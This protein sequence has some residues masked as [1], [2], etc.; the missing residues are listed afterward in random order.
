MGPGRPFIVQYADFLVGAVRPDFGDS[1]ALNQP[2][3]KLLL[4]RLPATVQLALDGLIISFAF[5]IPLGILS[6]V[7][8]DSIFDKIGKT[9]AVFGLAAPRFWVAIMLIILFGRPIW[10]AA[11][12]RS[13][14]HRRLVRRSIG[15]TGHDSSPAP[16]GIRSGHYRNRRGHAANP[17][18]D[19]GPAGQ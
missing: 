12:P 14:R 4:E 11:H 9:F 13:R 6:A 17:L 16:A 7:K 8:R 2:V 15:N 5:G 3:G 19:A 18:R 10:L 1:F